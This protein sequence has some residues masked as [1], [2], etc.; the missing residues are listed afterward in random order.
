MASTCQEVNLRAQQ[1]QVAD[2]K[3][4]DVRLLE[5]EP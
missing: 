3:I 1:N 5:F 4:N 2:L